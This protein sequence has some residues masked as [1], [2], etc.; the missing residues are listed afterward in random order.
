SSMASLSAKKADIHPERFL[1]MAEPILDHIRQLR[2]EIDEYIGA[3]AVR[4][5]EAPLWLRMQ[6]PGIELE[7]APTSVLTAMI[8]ILRVGVQAVALFLHRGAVGAR[9][10]AALKQACDFRVVGLAPGSVQVGLRLPEL[11]APMANGG[12]TQ[13][14]A[15]Q[16]L[17]LYLQAAAWA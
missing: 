6:G 14:H 4:F 5:A 11:P 17:H 3:T 13:A 15:Q 10:T 12:Q 8:D 9:P 1:L 2:A 7:D 16:A